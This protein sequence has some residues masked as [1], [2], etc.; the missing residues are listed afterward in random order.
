[1]RL[2][3]GNGTM[4]RP[5]YL[6]TIDDRT[7]QYV[8]FSA[9]ILGLILISGSRWLFR[10]PAAVGISWTNFVPVFIAVA[11]IT[12]YVVY[13]QF[14]TDR[15]SIS[16]DRAGDNA[17]YLGLI[18]TL[19]SLCISLVYLSFQDLLG[20]KRVLGLLPDFGVALIS[21]ISS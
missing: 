7:D 19:V 2:K 10:D 18:F 5:R 20:A 8:F 9:V 16:V 21:T 12:L 15:T 13:I 4:A 11:V 1:M 17:Y 3:C 14:S 6:R